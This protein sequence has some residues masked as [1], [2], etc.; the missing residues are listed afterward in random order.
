MKY[1]EMVTIIVTSYNYGQYLDEC[2]NSLHNQTYKN[3]EIIIVDD[4]SNDLFTLNKLHELKKH[5]ENIIHIENSGVSV[6]RNIGVQNAKG[7]YIIFLDG[8]DK[9]APQFVEKV[10]EIQNKNEDVLLIYS[11]TRFFGAANRLRILGNHPNYNR[12]L[13]NNYYFGITCLLHKN[14]ILQVGGFNAKMRHG[15]EDWEFFIRYCYQGMKVGRVNSALFYYRIKSISR[16]QMISKSV[17]KTLLMRMEII[18][19]NLDLYSEHFEQLINFRL[20]E[21]QGRTVNYILYKLTNGIKMYY[22]Y[23]FRYGK[24]EIFSM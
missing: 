5:G 21:R 3:I 14:R 24:C 23:I 16:T 1:N 13:I 4:G 20:A 2:I 7:N 6:A 22:S 8:D 17:K 11:Y 19:N 9:L 15:I 18:S 12:L 10:M